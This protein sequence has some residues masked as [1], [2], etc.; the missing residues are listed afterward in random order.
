MQIAQTLS[1]RNDVRD[2]CRRAGPAAAF[3]SLVEVSGVGKTGL[4]S[5][6]LFVSGFKADRIWDAG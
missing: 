5:R 6:L 3:E 1:Q 4:H 2:L